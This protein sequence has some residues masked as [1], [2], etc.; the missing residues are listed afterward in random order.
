M[1]QHEDQQQEMQEPAWPKDCL[2]RKQVVLCPGA[3]PGEMQEPTS[4]PQCP[5]LLC[6]PTSR[7][8][9]WHQFDGDVKRVLVTTVGDNHRRLK[10]TITI[11]V[12]LGAQRFGQDE[13][14]T[15]PQLRSANTR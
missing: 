13:K 2:S 15:N 12:S 10:Y 11:L 14:N 5:K 8:E 1:E 6:T 7:I 3:T 9:P 4:T